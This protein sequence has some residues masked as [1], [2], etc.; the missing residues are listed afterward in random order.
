MKRLKELGTLSVY[1]MNRHPVK[2]HARDRSKKT[3][4]RRRQAEREEPT[5]SSCKTYAQETLANFDAQAFMQQLGETATVVCLLARAQPSPSSPPPAQKLAHE[6][7][8]EVVKH[9]N[10]KLTLR[11]DLIYR[12]RA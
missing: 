10:Q 2:S 3:K 11:R 4:E 9:I 7:R 8:V 6:L 12:V 5:D 1:C